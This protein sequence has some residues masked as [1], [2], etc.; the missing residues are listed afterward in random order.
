MLWCKWCYRILSWHP[1]WNTRGYHHW[2]YYYSWW[3]WGITIYRNK[4]SRVIT[5]TRDTE[6]NNISNEQEVDDISALIERKF[7]ELSDK[8]EKT[9]HNIEAQITG[10]QLANISGN[11]VSGKAAT[12]ESFLYV[13]ILKNRI[14]ELEKQLPENNIIIDFVTT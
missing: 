9:L 4:L 6:T 11:N 2:R 14:L 12:S 13:D 8:V 1:R 3:H 10:I 7:N 5:T